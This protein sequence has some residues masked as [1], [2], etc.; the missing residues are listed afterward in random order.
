[1]SVRAE[2]LTDRN[3]RRGTAATDERAPGTRGEDGDEGRKVRSQRTAKNVAERTPGPVQ[4]AG[5]VNGRAALV[6]ADRNWKAQT[7]S[8]F[9]GT[10][11]VVG[12]AVHY[13]DERQGATPVPPARQA[14]NRS[15]LVTRGFGV[16]TERRPPIPPRQGK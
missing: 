13:D 6:R 8:E 10:A 2:A 16:H 7:N 14:A 12:V 11:R 3:R 5:A 9:A 1:M 15:A 4:P